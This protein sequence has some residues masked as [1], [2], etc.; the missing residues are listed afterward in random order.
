MIYQSYTTL[1]FI[2]LYWFIIPATFFGPIVEHSLGSSARR[3]PY[4]LGRNI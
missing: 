3:W 1:Y 2:R 4:K